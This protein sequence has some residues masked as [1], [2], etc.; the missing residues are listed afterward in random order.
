[1]ECHDKI[2][3][4]LAEDEAEIAEGRVLRPPSEVSAGRRPF[5]DW[6]EGHR[7]H[8]QDRDQRDRH[9]REDRGIAED[10]EWNGTLHRKSTHQSLTAETRSAHAPL[11]LRRRPG[12]I[13]RQHRARWATLPCWF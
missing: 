4:R 8:P 13:S 3:V 11:A 1:V 7:Y 2:C 12:R 10:L 6:L 9:C 5:G